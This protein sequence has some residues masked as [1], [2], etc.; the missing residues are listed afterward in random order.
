MTFAGGDAVA[1]LAK[2]VARVCHVHCK[3]VRPDVIRLARNRN[4]SFLAVGAQRRVHRARRRRVDFRRA[5]RHAARRTAIAGWLVVEAEQDPVVA[6]SYAYAEKGYRRL[7]EHRRRARRERKRSCSMSLLL[8]KAAR[9]GATI[10]ASRPQSAGWRY[11]GFAALSAAR[12]RE[13]DAR[14]AGGRELCIVVLAGRVDVEARRRRRG[15]TLGNRDERVRRRAARARSTLPDGGERRGHGDDRCR[16]RRRARARAAARCRRACIEPASMKRSVRGKG[17][18]TRYVLRHPAAD[19]ARRAPAGRRGAHAERALVE[20]SAAQ[21]RHRRA[22]GR[23]LARGNLLP[24]AQSRRRASR[25]SAS[26]PT[27]ARSTSR[28]PSRTTTS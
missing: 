13:R 25:S 2:H 22:A 11:V 6:P 3:D 9:R 19:R 20:L 21:A 7:R 23:E 18:N 16:D 15:A 26:T 1:M 27:T 28:W 5:A 17:A 12:R 4:W 24:P 14:D 8:V 10:V